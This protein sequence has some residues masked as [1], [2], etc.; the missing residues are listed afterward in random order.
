MN[1][2]RS[3]LLLAITRRDQCYAEGA[4]L[5][6]AVVR[7]VRTDGTGVLGLA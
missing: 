2:L 6:A 4:D 1:K 5:V 3:R 7:F